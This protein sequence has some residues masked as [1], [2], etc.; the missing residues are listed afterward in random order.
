ML[1]NMDGKLDTNAFIDWLDG[2]E[3]YYDFYHMFDLER[4][5]FAKIKLTGATRKYWQS[6]QHNMKR[7]KEPPITQW[8]IMKSKLKKNR[9][10]F[11]V[12]HRFINRLRLDIQ[13]E[14]KL[15]SPETIEEAYHKALE[16]K[17][18]YHFPTSRRFA[19]QLINLG[20]YHDVLNHGKDNTYVFKLNEK[21]NH[22]DTCQTFQK[23]SSSKPKPKS[24]LKTKAT[25]KAFDEIKLKITKAPVLGHPNF[26]KVFEVACDASS[27]GI[28]GVLS[29]EGHPISF[30]SEKLNEAKQWYSTYDREFYA[31]V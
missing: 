2:I 1:L 23:N 7:L 30:F 28:G 6:V 5:C 25:A 21:K 22:F 31:I 27:V 26:D 24:S 10:L 8:A 29:E 3:E 9:E 17:S 20:L 13:K 12:L 19:S 16:I 4:V 14:L 18:Y 15:H 11:P